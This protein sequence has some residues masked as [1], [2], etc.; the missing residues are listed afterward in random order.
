MY[1]EDDQNPASSEAMSIEDIASFVRAGLDDADFDSQSSEDRERL[2]N[3]Y[4]GRP[5][6]DEVEG[7]SAVVSRDVMETTEW[8]LAQLLRIF[9]GERYAEFE[10]FDENDVD[11]AAQQSDYVNYVI[12]QENDGVLLFHDWFKDALLLRRGIVHWGYE[13]RVKKTQ[14]SYTGISPEAL[15]M[16]LMDPNVELSAMTERQEVVEMPVP[17][18]PQGMPGQPPMPQ[19]APQTMP[20]PITLLDVELTRIER[21]RKLKVSCVPPEEFF[22]Q[23]GA[24]TIDEATICGHKAKVTRSML[25]EMGIPREKVEILS[26]WSDSTTGQN[27]SNARSK[28]SDDEQFLTDSGTQFETLWLYY[29]HVRL[30]IDGDGIAELLN[31]KYAGNEILSIEPALEI[32]YA[33]LCPIRTPHRFEGLGY[34][35]IVEDLQRIKTVLWRSSL[36]N[37][38]LTVRP[39]NEVV[40]R[41]LEH[42]EDLDEATVGGNIRVKRQGTVTPL[43]TPPMMGEALNMIQYA[44]SVREDRTGLSPIN[45][46]RDVDQVHETAKGMAQMVSQSQM[47]IELVARLFADTGV[48]RLFAGIYNA[49]VRN[50]DMPRMIRLRDKFVKIDPRE[51]RERNN[52]IINVALGAGTREAQTATLQMI[53]TLQ[54]TLMEKNI[55]LANVKNL[56]NTL[57]KLIEISGFKN[58]GSYIAD[59]D[60]FPP[61]QPPPPSDA[62]QVANI[63]KEI[64]GAKLKQQQLKFQD[65]Q[66]RAKAEMMARENQNRRQYELELAK[67]RADEAEK[68]RKH[69]LELARLGIE[70]EDSEKRREDE[71]EQFYDKL[72]QEATIERE[73]AQFAD[74]TAVAS[75]APAKGD[76]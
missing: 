75:N 57:R 43:V 27:E 73:R 51:W 4:Y 11:A 64:E 20:V 26:G 9:S 8:M 45:M 7:Y 56:E 44:N 74:L 33:S 67:L 28:N 53:A 38:Y 52:V 5:Y 71:A 6:G 23:K 24:R 14:E 65:E 59:P 15:Q 37:A 60:S 46:G 49:T 16:M 35:D 19:G 36:D 25:I 54:Q 62:I 47:R 69:E 50:Q 18:M 61:P 21:T 70:R 31:I 12:M 76:E 42:P 1:D 29:V 17:P 48:K 22:L 39:R 63:Q 72:L 30:D 34:G 55:P 41:D 40:W 66:Q 13:T 10:P 68:R 3:A 2:L 58:T 32:S